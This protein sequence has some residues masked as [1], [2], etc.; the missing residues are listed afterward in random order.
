MQWKGTE[1]SA[2]MNPRKQTRAVRPSARDRAGN[3]PLPGRHV[4]AGPR[5]GK[6]TGCTRRRRRSGQHRNCVEE[7]ATH[8][9][10]KQ[11][12]R[13]HLTWPTRSERQK[14]TN[15]R[16]YGGRPLRPGRLLGRKKVTPLHTRAGNSRQENTIYSKALLSNSKEASVQ[17]QPLDQPT[18]LA[19]GD[20]K[21][22]R[23]TV[24]GRDRK[25]QPEGRAPSPV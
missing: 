2:V 3:T 21:E 24:S 9:P 19:A 1:Q 25:G 23:T 22:T 8:Q 20:T 6:R 17:Q 10:N 13:A 14:A 12:S 5:A 7:P 11:T 16:K 15:G 4:P 18:T